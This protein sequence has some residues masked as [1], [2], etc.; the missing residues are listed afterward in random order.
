MTLLDLLLGLY[1]YLS[2]KEG[3][4]HVHQMQDLR[5]SFVVLGV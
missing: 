3:S 2:F 4:P 1:I 5:Y